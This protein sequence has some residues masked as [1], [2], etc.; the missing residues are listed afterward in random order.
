[1]KKRTRRSWVTGG[2]VGLADV[3][4]AILGPI[5][6]LMFIFVATTA[7][8]VSHSCQSLAENELQERAKQ[9]KDWL[10][11]EEGSLDALRLARNGACDAVAGNGPPAQPGPALMPRFLAGICGTDFQRIFAKAEIGPDKIEAVNA[12]RSALNRDLLRCLGTSAPGQ[13]ASVPDEATGRA[14]AEHLKQWVDESKKIL[15]VARSKI[16]ELCATAQEFET[17]RLNG[18]GVLPRLFEELCPLDRGNVLARAGISRDE[19]ASL[20]GDLDSAHRTLD[21][22]APGRLELGCKRLQSPGEKAERQA[23]VDKVKEWSQQTGNYLSKE[24]IAL[25]ERCPDV[26]VRPA[27]VFTL[28]V[29]PLEGATVCPGEH[30]NLLQEAGVTQQEMV[31]LQ[32]RYAE[33]VTKMRECLSSE[34]ITTT[35]YSVNFL[36]CRLDYAEIGSETPL[37]ADVIRERFGD[38]AKKILNTL[39]SARYKY[40]RIDVLG[41]TDDHKINP[42]KPCEGGAKTN[43]ELSSLRA[44]RFTNDLKEAIDRLAQFDSSARALKE[45]IAAGTLRLYAIG[46]GEAE[47]ICKPANTDSARRKNRR[48]EFRYAYERTH[49]HSREIVCGGP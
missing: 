43:A 40:N 20:A 47:P 11:T 7:R 36:N 17:P 42:Q 8:N 6:F 49:T 48:I 45:R 26:F 46:V 35:D 38:I 3:A 27:R 24:E 14:M 1:M 25:N 37:A 9:L 12:T 4:I 21:A 13:C 44:H 41:H 23:L 34:I 32:R 2:E 30:A 33:L 28:A 19:L 18:A 10:A 16:S 29:T 39:A 31:Q 22:C 15:I 5:A